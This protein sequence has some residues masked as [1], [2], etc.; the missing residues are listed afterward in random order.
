MKLHPF[1]AKM[2]YNKV[3]IVNLDNYSINGEVTLD[4]GNYFNMLVSNFKTKTI[5]NFHYVMDEEIKFD[6]IRSIFYNFFLRNLNKCF[7]FILSHKKN[8]TKQMFRDIFNTE[9]WQ[10]YNENN[11][12]TLKLSETCMF[13]DFIE[14]VFYHKN[15]SKIQKIIQHIDNVNLSKPNKLLSEK[16]SKIIIRCSLSIPI[17]NTSQE[18][19]NKEAST[20]LDINGKEKSTLVDISSTLNSNNQSNSEFSSYEDETIAIEGK[21]ESTIKDYSSNFVIS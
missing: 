7:S 15:E 20:T 17:N 19:D 3:I 12:F 6:K 5:N 18:N 14:K 10:K 8:Y 21:V 4:F 9:G 1:Q 11:K 13:S 2:L 16:R